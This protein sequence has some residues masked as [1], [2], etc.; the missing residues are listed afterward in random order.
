M[1]GK[2]KSIDYTDI[3]LYG[4]LFILLTI[5]LFQLL[6]LWNNG[7]NSLSNFFTSTIPQAFENTLGAIETALTGGVT[8]PVSS[9]SSLFDWIPSLLSLI[10][11]FFIGLITGLIPGA[12]AASLAS[13]A[14]G[15]F[16][17]TLPA[18]TGNGSSYSPTIS[19]TPT[20]TG[21]TYTVTPGGDGENAL[22][23]NI[24]A[25]NTGDGD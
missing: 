13:D 11:S 18:D 4:G 17:S 24:N 10:W 14:L 20:G 6:K 7:N 5:F 21:S 1:A 22:S 23:A 9:I 16:G 15:L 25:P 12:G 8:S 3:L 19:G 2:K